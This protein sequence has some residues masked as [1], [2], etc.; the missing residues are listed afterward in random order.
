MLGNVALARDLGNIAKAS[1]GGKVRKLERRQSVATVI[2]KLVADHR[3]ELEAEAR[4]VR[5]G[6]RKS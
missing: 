2:E 5:G 1:K 4:M 6:P 3:E